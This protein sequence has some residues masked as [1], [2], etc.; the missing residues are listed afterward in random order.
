[1]Q[2]QN[3][4]LMITEQPAFFTS[5]AISVKIFSPIRIYGNDNT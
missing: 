4:N 2:K 1:M 3:W 5:M